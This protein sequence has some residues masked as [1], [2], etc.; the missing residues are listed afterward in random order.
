MTAGVRV[1]Q[2]PPSVA[3]RPQDYGLFSRQLSADELAG[4][5]CFSDDD[6]RQIARHRRDVNRLGFAVQLGTVRYLG[7]FLEN[8]AQAPEQVVHWTAREIGVAP[9]TNL[10]G[11]GE[12]E[13]RWDHQAEIRAAYG[14]RPFSTPGVEADLVE[15]LRARGGVTAESHAVLFARA[16]EFLIGRRILL[17]GWSTLW[18]LVGSARES[19]MSAAGRCSSRPSRRSS[20][21]GWN[22]CCAS[23]AAIA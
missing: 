19:A 14:Y 8:P 18:R 17:P 21:N 7:R 9:S 4:C 5:F 1:L 23:L 6:Q 3:A 11:Y 22:G 2:F 16:G 15:W 13:G 12:G 10:A 20:A